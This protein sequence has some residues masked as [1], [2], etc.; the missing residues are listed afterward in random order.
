MGEVDSVNGQTGMVV[1]DADDIDDTSTTQ[2]FVTAADITKLGNLSGVNTGDQDLSVRIGTVA[3]SGTPSIDCDLYDQYNITAL[4]AAIT[5]I[6]ITGT[7]TDGQRLLI[8][9]KDDGTARAVSTG[10]SII[11]S[12]TASFITNTVISKT[13]MMGIIYDAAAAKWVTLAADATGY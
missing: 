9:I 4:A 13:H 11:S 8:R 10:A 7:P 1:L 5:S 2:K 3:S 12:G 6:T